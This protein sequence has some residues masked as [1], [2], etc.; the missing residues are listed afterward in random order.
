[1]NAVD[2]AE[3]DRR[4]LQVRERLH[5]GLAPIADVTA[6]LA[7]AGI[8]VFV[9]PLGD[10]GPMG[11][12][13]RRPEFA[14][15]LL[16]SDTYLPRLRFT[17]AHELGH[18]EYGSAGVLDQTVGVFSTDPEEQRANVF[19]AAFLMPRDALSRHVAA[20]QDVSPDAVLELSSEL[21]VSYESLVFRLHNVG[22]LSGGAAK[23]DALQAARPMV[24]TEQLR[25]RKIER[26]TVLPPDYVVRALRAYD[27][28]EIS[29]DRL[30]E[31]LYTDEAQLRADL[32]DSQ[33][34]H[35]EDQ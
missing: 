10:R 9:R 4:A 1:M 11:A 34:L 2:F 25:R 5:L 15:V 26:R 33:L 8:V 14:A 20:D 3:V 27:L 31:L 13:V 7:D 17:A 35:P 30:A 29:L 18:H 23:R 12:Y 28:Y 24:L 16:N 19:A 6:V 21:G 22:L 32:S